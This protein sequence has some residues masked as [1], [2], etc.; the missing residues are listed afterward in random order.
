MKQI[1]FPFLLL[2]SSL[3]CGCDKDVSSAPGITR[4]IP[5]TWQTQRIT[6]EGTERRIYLLPLAESVDYSTISTPG[7]LDSS[8]P[9]EVLQGAIFYWRSA[10][11]ENV[12]Q[13][14]AS[15]DPVQQIDSARLAQ[16]LG[17][18]T[19]REDWRMTHMVCVG[20]VLIVRGTFVDTAKGAREIDLW[21]F[22]RI[23]QKWKL[24]VLSPEIKSIG[25][26]MR[27]LYQDGI[28]LSP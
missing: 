18:S 10:K 9:L 14:F 8:D 22:S 28:T 12:K 27:L 2:I 21:P 24:H 13:Y 26:L 5:G 4:L 15:A 19:G 6:H 23:D 17:R 25:W 3:L 11:P 1:S 20:E 16:I 7:D